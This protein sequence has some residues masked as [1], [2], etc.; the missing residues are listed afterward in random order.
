MSRL[1]V[2]WCASAA[3]KFAVERWHYSETMPP[4]KT[5]RMGVWWDGV[6]KGAVIFSRPCRNQ[7]LMFGLAPQEVCELARVAL[8]RH[9]GF[10][11]TEVVARAIRMLKRRCPDLRLIVSFADPAEG[12]IGKIYQAGNWIYTGE[13]AAARML[14]HQG[15]KLHRR[16]YTGATFDNPRAKPPPGSVWIPVPGKHRYLMPLD[17]AMRRQVERLRKP[18][19]R[20]AD[21]LAE[22][23]GHQ[24]GQVVRAHP[25]ASPA[26]GAGT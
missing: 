18:Y 15:K 3:A 21:A 23:T 5:V 16:H 14:V 7:H 19:P 1:R 13:S 9:E 25:S 12:H 22:G 26:P 20:S 24:P 6:F 11:V 4:I 10:H 17:R 8:D 2:D